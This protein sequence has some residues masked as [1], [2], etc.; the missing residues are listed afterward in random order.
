MFTYNRNSGGVTYPINDCRHNNI[1]KLK[2]TFPD[3]GTHEFRPYGYGDPCDDGYFGVQAFAGMT[4]YSI[5]GTYARLV[6]DQS[7]WTLSFADGTLVVD[8]QGTQHSYDRNG[9]YTEIQT[10]TNYNNT[11]HQPR[12]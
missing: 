2:V 3:G 1:W 5:D 7:G 6:Y 12:L 11:G 10:V 9:N 4:Y 8:Q